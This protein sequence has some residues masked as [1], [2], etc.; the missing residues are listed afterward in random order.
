M[1]AIRKD[2]GF[3]LLEVLVCFSLIL[4]LT[5]F[6][7]LLIKNLFL[8]T[9]KGEGI[10]PLELEVFIQQATR[11]VRNAKTVSVD[12]VALVII[13]EADQRVTY[14]YY[15][16]K[17]RRRVNGTGHELLL[18]NVQSVLFEKTANGAIFKVKGRDHVTHEFRISAIPDQW[19][20]E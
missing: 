20:S 16:Q 8:L 14:E 6:F 5:A 12:G 10:H 4:I 2:E 1:S 18:H 7:P 3:T 19:F 11:E 13:N 17:L 15:Q 9:Q